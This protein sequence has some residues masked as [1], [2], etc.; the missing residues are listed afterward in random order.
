MSSLTPGV[1]VAMHTRAE[2]LHT[3]AWMDFFNYVRG[4]LQA[5]R[6]AAFGSLLWKSS[7]MELTQTW[8]FWGLESCLGCVGSLTMCTVW[9]QEG[10]FPFSFC[11]NLD[12]N[13]FFGP[14]VWHRPICVGSVPCGG[15]H[16]RASGAAEG[17][18]GRYPWATPS[19]PCLWGSRQGGI[20]SWRHHEA[21]AFRIVENM[22]AG[23]LFLCGGHGLA[24][25]EWCVP[26]T[27]AYE[28]EQPFGA[29]WVPWRLGRIGSLGHAG[30]AG[31]LPSHP[32]QPVEGRYARSV[33]EEATSAPSAAHPTASSDYKARESAGS[34]SSS[35]TSSA[36]A[37]IGFVIAA[38]PMT[39]GKGRY[40]LVA[41]G[42]ARK[43]HPWRGLWKWGN[44]A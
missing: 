6:V 41:A 23:L 5:G 31:Y 42:E 28:R 38:R 27:T 29:S 44:T 9:Y 15:R 19:V 34:R 22:A 11:G 26:M 13:D 17:G 2:I 12:Q 3:A 10:R 21:G 25:E 32:A 33:G 39:S 8:T 20:V 40:A 7:I 14:R 36:L 4:L 24:A 35:S 16:L 37:Q 1:H 43:L 18:L 30:C